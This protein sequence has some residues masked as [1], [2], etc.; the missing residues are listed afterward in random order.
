M[1]SPG[2]T[3]QRVQAD[4]SSPDVNYSGLEKPG[5]SCSNPGSS[6]QAGSSHTP[7]VS[8]FPDLHKSAIL[9]CP[10]SMFPTLEGRG[11]V[12]KNRVISTFRARSCA[13][14]IKAVTQH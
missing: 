13:I 14:P 5:E 7:V 11:I 4:L 6:A 3:L 2:E 10:E 9:L 12:C 1:V 8:L